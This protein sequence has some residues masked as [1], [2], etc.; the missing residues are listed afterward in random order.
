MGALNLFY[1]CLSL[2]FLIPNSLMVTN[3]N[4]IS[5]FV[6]AISQFIIA[7]DMFILNNENNKQY[8]FSVKAYAFGSSIVS[9]SLSGLLP[10][11]PS[12]PYNIKLVLLQITY[13]LMVLLFLWNAF[14]YFKN[15]KKHDSQ[16]IQENI[17]TSQKNK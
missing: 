7:I 17:T 14:V 11:I 1:S 8:P 12:V 3:S 2:T 16:P 10:L 5:I 13:W 9:A 4:A 6:F 15:L